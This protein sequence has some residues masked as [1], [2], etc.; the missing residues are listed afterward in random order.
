M[1]IVRLAPTAAATVA[2]LI[3]LVG[4]SSSETPSTPTTSGTSTAAEAGNCT[5]NPETTP[6]PSVEEFRSVPADARISVTMSGIPSGVIKPGD[7]PT[8][9]EVT[10]CNDSPVD[11]PKVG[12]TFVI[13][14]CSCATTPVGLPEGNVDRFDAATNAWVPS[15]HPVITTGMDYLG[16]FDDVPSLPKGKS[17]TLRY[18]ISLDPSM[19]AGKGGVSAT[20]VVPDPLVQ[21]GKADLPFTVLQD[22]TKDPAAPTS[23]PGPSPRQSVLPFKGL[24]YPRHIATS[25]NGDVYVTDTVTNRVLKL[26]AGSNEQ[27]VLPFTG[28]DGPAGVAVDDTGNVFVA[29]SKNRRVVKLAAGSNEQTVLPITGL[30]NPRR[31]TV[32][33]DNNLYVTDDSVGVVKLA[34]GADRATTLPFTNLKYPGSVAVDGA[35][36]VFVADPSGDRILE[37]AA[38]TSA[39]TEISVGGLSDSF[40]VDSAGDIYVT[41]VVNKKVTKRAAGTN[42]T[43]T[44][45]FAGLNGPDGIAVDA[46]GNVYVTDNSGFGRIVKLTA[47]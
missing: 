9:V 28:L 36:D 40:A 1:K 37:L 30:N 17:V 22:S 33:S 43:S 41:D 39:P 42:D 15:R 31:V 20:A 45:A 47:R 6:M 10:L 8:D 2:A 26:A 7:P 25:P 14:K 11:Y 16:G 38:G 44:L 34:S 3:A 21:I 32:D 18:R 24:T 29:D 13:N 46:A 23:M 27:A 12:L 4:C 5:V 19:T 35:G